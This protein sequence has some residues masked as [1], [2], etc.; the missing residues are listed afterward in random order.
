MRVVPNLDLP[1][2][3]SPRF[4]PGPPTEEAQVL[5]DRLN[6]ALI[7]YVQ[8]YFKVATW[9]VIL[10]VMIQLWSSRTIV[11]LHTTRKGCLGT[12]R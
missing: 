11:T 1:A 7:A 6:E 5:S 10:P 9:M 8:L 12:L 4:K 3:C 2:I